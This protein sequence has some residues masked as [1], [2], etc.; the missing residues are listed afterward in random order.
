[1]ESLGTAKD[2]RTGLHRR[3]NRKKGRK[4]YKLILKERKKK[5]FS[6]VFFVLALERKG[7]ASPSRDSEKGKKKKRRDS[8]GHCGKGSRRAIRAK[9]R[10]R[11]RRE[12][13]P[14]PRVRACLEKVH[15]EA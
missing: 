14:W 13:F 8:R 10:D 4:S 9:L 7:E 6:A 11:K 2:C 3:R 12:K 1:L 5:V 15:L